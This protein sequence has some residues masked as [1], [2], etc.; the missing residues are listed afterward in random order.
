MRNNLILS[1]V[2]LA[3]LSACSSEPTKSAAASPIAQPIELDLKVVLVG[4]YAS[5]RSYTYSTRTFARC[6]KS[7]PTSTSRCPGVTRRRDSTQPSSHVRPKEE[8]RRHFDCQAV[9]RVVE[10][11]SRA[12][13]DQSKLSVRFID[14]ADL[15]AEASHWAGQDESRLVRARHVE[16]ALDEKVYRIQPA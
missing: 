16:R 12:V 13:Q 8:G 14:I 2:T 1:C 9:A 15:V 3:L 6:S 4:R 5:T 10:H 11:G 7:R